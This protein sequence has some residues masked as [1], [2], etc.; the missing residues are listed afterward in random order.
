[1]NSEPAEA[2]TNYPKMLYRTGTEIEWEGWNLDTRIVRDEDEELAAIEDGW[3]NHPDALD[4][5]GDGRKG[6]APKRAKEAT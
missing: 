6:G 5:D 2:D 3:R 1:M 4:H